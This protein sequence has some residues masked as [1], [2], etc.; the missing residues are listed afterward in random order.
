[1]QNLSASSAFRSIW[2]RAPHVR[3]NFVQMA[4]VAVSCLLI[5]MGPPWGLVSGCLN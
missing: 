2:N 3:A 5:D 1:M 4:A